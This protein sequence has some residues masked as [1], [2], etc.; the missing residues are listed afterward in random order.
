M[1]KKQASF[2]Q[3]VKQEFEKVSGQLVGFKN[4]LEQTLA[5]AL[6]KQ[7]KEFLRALTKCPRGE[8]DS[9]KKQKI[10]DDENML[11]HQGRP[12]NLVHESCPLKASGWKKQDVEFGA[13]AWCLLVLCSF[14]QQLQWYLV[15]QCQVQHECDVGA[16][17]PSG[18][19]GDTGVSQGATLQTH[20][21][22]YLTCSRSVPLW[23][24]G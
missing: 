4:T 19:S 1:E 22:D 18:R 6:E 17:V 5:A 20:W 8:A 21:G 14:M 7:S 24:V 9:S 12:V 13:N 2:S 11:W 10:S 15:F 3:D 23:F 16:W